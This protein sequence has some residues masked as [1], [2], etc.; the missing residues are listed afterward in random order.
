VVTLR[1]GGWHEERVLGRPRA[2]DA[3]VQITVRT[4]QP[5][6]APAPRPHSHLAGF[7]LMIPAP[8]AMAVASC[9]P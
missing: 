9:H 4:R 6:S 2:A 8:E 5:A 3:S 7:T 1:H